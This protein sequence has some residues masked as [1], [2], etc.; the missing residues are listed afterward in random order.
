MA[1]PSL[2]PLTVGEVLDVSFGLYRL[3]FAPLVVIAAVTQ[4]IP[5]LLSVYMAAA[6]GAEEHVPLALATYCLAIFLSAFGVAASTFVVSDTYLG[7][8]TSASD[9]LSR[10]GALIGRLVAISILAWL[11]VMVGMILLIIPGIILAAGLALS[12]VVAV[13]EGPPSAT[14]A[15]GRSWQLTKSYRGKVLLTVIVS[16][17]LL[18]VPGIAVGVATALFTMLVG[19]AGRLIAVILQ[20]GLQVCVYPFV[21]VVLT[22][23]YYDIRVRKEGFDLEL[24]ASALPAT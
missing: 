19:G 21:Y 12:A 11:L 10:A 3:L 14:A 23:L 20:S 8:E 18:M 2:R 24:L 22:V 15:M 6:G 5:V 13:V 1:T 17:L 7:R 4:L 9:A 16:I